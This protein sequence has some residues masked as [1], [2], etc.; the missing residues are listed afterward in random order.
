MLLFSGQ[1]PGARLRPDAVHLHVRAEGRGPVRGHAAEQRARRGPEEHG[2]A[3]EGDRAAAEGD[4]HE[5]EGDYTRADLQTR[6]LRESKR[7]RAWGGARR[8]RRREEEGAGHQEHHGGCVQGAH[9]HSN[10][11]VPDSTV[12][13]TEVGELGGKYFQLNRRLTFN[14]KCIFIVLKVLLYRQEGHILFIILYIYFE[15]FFA[16]LL[17]H[18]YQLF[19]GLVSWLVRFYYYEP[20]KII[21][22]S[23]HLAVTLSSQTARCLKTVRLRKTNPHALIMETSEST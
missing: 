13:E 15:A 20:D 9:G 5:P 22:F 19:V 4:H 3:A 23:G 11:A 1:G 16:F 14:L 10:A 21:G 8:R 2:H 12:P 7:P 18:L 17:L 6:A